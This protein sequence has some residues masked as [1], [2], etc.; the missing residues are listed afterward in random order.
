MYV[1]YPFDSLV[2]SGSATDEVVKS[3][4]ACVDVLRIVI[5]GDAVKE[6]VESV[7]VTELGTLSVDSSELVI[8]TNT[9]D[10]CEV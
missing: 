10:C 9:M 2:L 7:I 1:S 5:I 8:V 4:L 3:P 6:T